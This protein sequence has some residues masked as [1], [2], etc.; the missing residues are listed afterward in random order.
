MYIK[1][2]RLC[3]FRGG[4]VCE[5]IL[6]SSFISLYMYMYFLLV[7]SVG[8][9]L[10]ELVS[11]VTDL[12]VDDKNEDALSIADSGVGTSSVITAA[13]EVSP[14]HSEKSIKGDCLQ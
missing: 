12:K 4:Q 8:I 1:E 3:P 14:S 6:D 7:L 5:N 10:D 13:T 11:M 9:L 2:I